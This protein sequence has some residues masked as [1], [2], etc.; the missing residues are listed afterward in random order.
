MER[1]CAELNVDAQPLYDA[2]VGIELIHAASLVHDD[3][4][5]EDVER[6]EKPSF[7]SE[8]GMKN[9]VLYG[10]YF[11]VSALQ[12]FS[13]KKYPREIMTHVLSAV[14]QMTDAQLME[15]QEKVVDLESYVTYANGKTTSLFELCARIPLEY[16]GI[17]HRHAL[18]FAQKY[19]LAFQ[20]SDDLSEEKD[21]L[22]IQRFVGREN[23]LNYLNQ[24][25]KELD[26]MSFI[27]RNELTFHSIQIQSKQ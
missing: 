21:E 24:I 5:D 16:Y 2:M 1:I 14:Q 15:T 6:R 18:S 7:H 3:I 27:T 19:G 13:Q 23:A 10:D 20:L 4:V 26:E 12:L 22:N 25:W 17:T 8:Y 9:S 11:F